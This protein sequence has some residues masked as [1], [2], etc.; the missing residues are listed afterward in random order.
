MVILTETRSIQT[1][2]D[3]DGRLALLGDAGR[4]VAPTSGSG[5]VARRSQ[6]SQRGIS[7]ASRPKRTLVAWTH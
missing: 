1:E 4:V 5:A 7:V 2:R 3:S 6:R